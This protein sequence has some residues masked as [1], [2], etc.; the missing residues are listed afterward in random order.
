[1][2]SI[3]IAELTNRCYFNIVIREN[4]MKYFVYFDAYGQARK[5]L[6]EEDLARRFGG[7]PGVFQKAAAQEEGERAGAGE[8]AAASGNVSVL[9]FESEEQLR[10]YLQS[11]GDEIEGFFNCAADSRPYNF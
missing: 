11:L 7:D 2:K 8:I 10:E 6:S 1:V 5:W 4:Q 9:N 3:S